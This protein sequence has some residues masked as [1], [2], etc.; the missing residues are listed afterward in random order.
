M[1]HVSDRTLYRHVG[2][3][4]VSFE[5]CCNFDPYYAPQR[6]PADPLPTLYPCTK[7]L[8][9]RR[10]LYVALKRISADEPYPSKTEL[11]TSRVEHRENDYCATSFRH[12][13]WKVRPYDW[14]P[15]AVLNRLDL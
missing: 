11:V 10:C 3:L 4:H 8:R 1:S 2:F 13:F 7:R 14:A 15:L 5:T 6:A 9:V 12:A